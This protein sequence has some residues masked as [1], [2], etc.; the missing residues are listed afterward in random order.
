[1]FVR[2]GERAPT[3]LIRTPYN[4][5]LAEGFASA[6]AVQGFNVVLQDCRGRFASSGSQSFAAYEDRD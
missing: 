3:M 1:M 5:L 4:K 6:I 2:T